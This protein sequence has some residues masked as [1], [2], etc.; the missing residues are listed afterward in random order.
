MKSLLEQQ[1]AATNLKKTLIYCVLD[2]RIYANVY[3]PCLEYISSFPL[4]DLTL[5]FAQF[6]GNHFWKSVV[7]TYVFLMMMMI[8]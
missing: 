7:S 2:D 3:L 8:I 5:F 4:V 6:V 1:K